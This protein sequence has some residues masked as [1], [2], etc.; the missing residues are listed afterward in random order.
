[1]GSDSCPAGVPQ[2][3]IL[4]AHIPLPNVAARNGGGLCKQGTMY[5]AHVQ[6]LA[7]SV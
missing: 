1:M 3:A 5:S 6:M 2:L 4:G 7:G